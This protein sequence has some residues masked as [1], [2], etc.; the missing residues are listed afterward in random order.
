[1]LLIDTYLNVLEP[2]ESKE[3]VDIAEQHLKALSPI[4]PGYQTH[5]FSEILNNLNKGY[6]IEKLIK[7]AN[8]RDY[9]LLKSWVNYSDANIKF[10]NWH[11]HNPP[12]RK[13]LVCYIKNPEQRGT[14]FNVDGHVFQDEAPENS[15]IVFNSSV[16]H[17]VPENITLPRYSLAIDFT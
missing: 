3:L 14:I 13:S 15:M 1:M 9:Q 16:L 17:T 6:L 11:T 8:L 12:I 10:T 4:H 5:E 7:Q 2:H